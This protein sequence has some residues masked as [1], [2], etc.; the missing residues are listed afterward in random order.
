MVIFGTGSLAEKFI[1]NNMWLY[2]YVGFFI[3]NNPRSSSYMKKEVISFKDFREQKNLYD[4]F[5]VVAS[6]FYKEIF[7]QL[8][9]IGLQKNDH[10]IQIFEKE[11]DQ[12]TTVNRVVNG[13]QVGR[14]TYGY[15]K[16]CYPN[17]IF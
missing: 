4:Y 16:H 17:S 14:F 11:I 5:I 15:S 6:S 1:L 2:K 8:H 7:K 9:G 13:V 10:Y 3:D 12:Q